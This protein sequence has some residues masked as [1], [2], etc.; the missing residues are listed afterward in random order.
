MKTRLRLS[1]WLLLALAVLFLGCVV[2]QELTRDETGQ[3]TLPV[4]SSAVVLAALAVLAALT[5]ACCFAKKWLSL[6]GIGF[7]LCHLAVVLFL[8]AAFVW[9]VWGA[10]VTLT[11]TPTVTVFTPLTGDDLPFSASLTDFT[12]TNRIKLVYDYAT[13]EGVDYKK[14]GQ[15]SLFV[16]VEDGKAT[17]LSDTLSCGKYG[18][19][20]KSELTDENGTLKDQFLYH[21]L[22]VTLETEH[23]AV[24]V[25]GYAAAITYSD[26]G[27]DTLSVNHPVMHDGWKLYLM[28]YTDDA[29]IVEAKHDPALPFAIAGLILCPVGTFL[30]CLRPRKKREEATA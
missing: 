10:K 17:F 16:T 9:F 26:G 19:V 24:S 12:V 27:S 20:P 22:L 29:V 5:V 25:D 2:L 28:S 6:R 1:V 11:L 23:A 15:A 13:P 18:K 4:Y 8:A 14:R 30:L 7:L 3:I 21:D